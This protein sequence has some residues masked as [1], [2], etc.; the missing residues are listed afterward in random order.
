VKR[1][2]RAATEEK[3]VGNGIYTALSGAIAQERNLNTVSQN[4]ANV[5]TTGYKERDV[6]F[7]EIVA[8]RDGT[9]RQVDVAD[10]ESET[11]AGQI[12]K[13]DN[14][15]D[16]AL[17]GEGFFRVGP[18]V[19][20]DDGSS[21]QLVTRDGNFQTLEDGTLVTKKGNPVMSVS[22]DKIRIPRDSTNININSN[23]VIKDDLG[24]IDQIDVVGVRDPQDLEPRADTN[25]QTTGEN[26]VANT[27]A[28]IQQGFLEKSNVDPM[29]NMT[30][31]IRIQ[32]HFET[33]TKLM[34]TFDSIDQKAIRQVGGN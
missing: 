23:G 14:P 10:V 13:T 4:L 11:S 2:L 12:K 24:F 27:N 30:E 19:A 33:M 32:R 5:N 7:E 26:L 16:L 1:K 6:S 8:N 31:M 22:G 17:K 20:G 3:T 28:E 9:A 18:T 21:Q 25:F 34:Q 15:L 29:K